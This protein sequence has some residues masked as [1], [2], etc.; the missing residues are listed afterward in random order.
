MQMKKIEAQ[1]ACWVGVALIRLASDD[2]SEGEVE[3]EAGG[4]S[5]PSSR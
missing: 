4:R 2:G 5:P 3:V 1:F